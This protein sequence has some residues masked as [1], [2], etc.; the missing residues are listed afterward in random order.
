[1][2]LRFL[3][4]RRMSLRGRFRTAGRNCGAK[5][6]HSP[7][8][9]AMLLLVSACVTVPL[10]SGAQEKP[11]SHPPLRL[12]TSA[13]SIRKMRP[14]EAARSYPVRLVGVITYY[15]PDTPDLL[16]VSSDSM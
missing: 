2:L 6:G 10:Q 13:A 7:G 3:L 8:L 11:S 4:S 9:P 16:S 12:I 15:D 5:A 14:E 1:M